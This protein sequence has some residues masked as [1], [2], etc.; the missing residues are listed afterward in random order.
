M[1][2]RR[3]AV[4]LVAVWLA[5]SPAAAVEAS[6]PEAAALARRWFHQLLGFD[7]LEAY[8]ARSGRQR[9]TFAVARKWHDG[10][11]RIV[12]K[13][14]EPSALNDLAVLI[15][16]NRDRS[17]DFFAY[18][19]FLRKVRRMRAPEFDFP[20]A[21]GGG[22]LPYAELR[23]FQPTELVHRRLPDEVVSGEA[24]RV[25]E[26]RPVTPDRE[27][28]R[29]EHAISERTGVALRTR[30]LLG[31]RELSRVDVDPAD[32]EERDGRYLPIR[33]QIQVVGALP[34]DLVLRNLMIDPALPDRLFTSHSLRFQRFPRF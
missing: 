10:L 33:R 32:V 19:D 15:V 24:C 29:L 31:G 13:V 23:P 28:D 21:I 22:R 4:A 18:L 17:D 5:A 9:V 30:Y 20:V 27:F 14:Q 1:T 3:L 7:A 8:E 25:V 34:Y 11:A 6:D 2:P 16:Q 26:S 12:L